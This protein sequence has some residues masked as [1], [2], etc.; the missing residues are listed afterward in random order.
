MTISK[1]NWISKENETPEQPSVKK[2]KTNRLSFREIIGFLSVWLIGEIFMTYVQWNTLRDGKGI[3][4]MIIRSISLGV[5]LFLIHYVGRQF[6]TQR[7]PLQLIFLLFSFL[8]LFT[9]LIGPL[10]MQELYP[11]VAS[12][13]SGASEWS[14]DNSPANGEPE[15]TDPYPFWV[16][17]YRNNDM[18]PGIFVFLF[19]VIMQTFGRSAPHTKPGEEKNELLT[20]NNTFRQTEGKMHIEE[21]RKYY[22]QQIALAEKRL[23]RLSGQQ[24]EA[25]S[26][27][28]RRLQEILDELNNKHDAIVDL[29]HKKVDLEVQNDHLFR[30]LELQLNRYR[31][32]FMNILNND[33]V[34]SMVIRPEW[35]KREDLVNYFK[36]N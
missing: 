26:P 14:L 31:I 33:P 8:M 32:E 6:K 28:T 17:F 19:F 25:V 12:T 21:R 34:K 2:K 22:Q 18:L 5:V 1:C 36:L 20:D 7:R 10:L 24:I 3:E 11:P 15:I 16:S 35:P 29:Q 27:N 30:K 23:A 13:V 4:D 9:M